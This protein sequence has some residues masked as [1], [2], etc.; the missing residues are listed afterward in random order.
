DRASGKRTL[1]S[2]ART[3][4]TLS[5]PALDALWMRLD[6]LDPLIKVL[7]RR[8]WAKRHYPFV[9]RP[10]YPPRMLT[11]QS[12]STGPHVHGGETVGDFSQ[13]CS[14]R[15]VSPWSLL[16]C[17]CHGPEQRLRCSRTI[18]KSVAPVASQS[19]GTCME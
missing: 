3:C 14:A 12:F 13:I 10:A 6:S 7:P 16:A 5:E 15:Q 19:H 1:G 4:R 18:P 11:T 2:L 8:M 9:V 17:L